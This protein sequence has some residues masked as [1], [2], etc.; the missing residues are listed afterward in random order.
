M[1]FTIP[2]SLRG[3]CKLFFNNVEIDLPTEVASVEI[4]SVAESGPGASGG[5]SEPRPDKCARKIF[6]RS[7][8]LHR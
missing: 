6:P 2:K 3:K 4:L 1:I 8:L 7:A 5:A